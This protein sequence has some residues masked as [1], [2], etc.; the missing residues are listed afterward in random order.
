[1]VAGRS[2][3]RGEYAR[4][5]KG[6]R[7]SVGLIIL[8]I[9]TGQ[10]QLVNM[11]DEPESSSRGLRL[12][13]R[14]F[15]QVSAASAV[16]APTLLDEYSE[17]LDEG[18][19]GA[20]SL[21]EEAADLRPPPTERRDYFPLE[22]ELVSFRGLAPSSNDAEDGGSTWLDDQTISLRN[23]AAWRS[24]SV[25]SQAF[26]QIFPNSV[27]ELITPQGEEIAVIPDSKGWENWVGDYSSDDV[28]NVGSPDSVSHLVR[29]VR[30]AAN[31]EKQFRA[32]G[33]GHSHS[34]AAAPENWYTNM[35][36]VS[37]ALNQ[38]W[39]R[40][41]LDIDS[42]YLVRI[43]AGTVLKRLNREILADKGLG[44]K[45]MG[46]FDGQ[47]L[48]GAINTSTHGT[49]LELKPL[50]DVVKSVEIIC[51]PES[52]YRRD[53]PYVRS[54]RIEPSDGITDPE[55]FAAD[56]DRHGMGLIQNDDLFHSVVVG[57]GCMGIVY[58]YTLEVRESYWLKEE[59]RLMD[60]NTLKEKLSPD[61]GE[62]KKEAVENFV[63]KDDT[64][65]FHFLLNLP[66][67]Q[68]PAE[69]S[70]EFVKSDHDHEGPN[71][72]VC[73]IKR[74]KMASP[75]KDG[76]PK[77]WDRPGTTYDTRWPPE[78]RK[79]PFRDIAKALTKLHPLG[80]DLEHSQRLHNNFFDPERAKKGPFKGKEPFAAGMEKTVWYIALRRPKD[81]GNY[82]PK[83]PRPTTT[84]E[85]AV[86]L[87]EL[88]EAIDAIRDKVD[89]IDQAKAIGDKYDPDKRDQPFSVFFPYPLG[90]RF[91]CE[92]T[93]YFSPEYDRKTAMLEVPMPVND[94]R[95]E[96]I[97]LIRG[98]VTRPSLTQKEARELVS[99]PALEKIQ[100]M[101]IE[102]HR[103][104]PHMGKHNTV[105]T[106]SENEK[107]RP[108]NM[109]P[110]YEKWLDAYRYLNA[111][112]T[113]DGEFSDNKTP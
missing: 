46:S 105:H 41:D 86:P 64:R 81:R 101:L 33:S 72:P 48:A 26:S 18:P 24:N 63:T 44:L 42:R 78:R 20:G 85:A 111:F 100:D 90:V 103:A 1:M 45:N 28:S 43:G 95:T 65:H 57:Y 19:Q 53:T 98:N 96:G 58:A 76:E 14:D 50:A 107:L 36:E 11:S 13:R 16:F 60:W 94:G 23:L 47:T 108:Q 7:R 2:I 68:I 54:L 109:Y 82:P 89:D 5:G 55:K 91:T 83:P 113:F 99:E 32:V 62:T 112:G 6:D 10:P 73:V 52:R 51:V 34:E 70:D 30:N 8:R 88:V 84:T 17:S 22:S 80:V 106:E 15:L 79:K 3:L 59:T 9:S 97:S 56:A 37:G 71:N 93:Q 110:E 75:P 49:G 66:T 87:E 39:L 74:R 12:S 92:S 27:R 40:D 29:L 69:L 35:K 67:D 104:R 4:M 38:P 21:S 61:P 31:N 25:P 102:N 77:W